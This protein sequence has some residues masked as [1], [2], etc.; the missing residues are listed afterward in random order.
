MGF[1]YLFCQ[2]T[3]TLLRGLFLPQ[4][5]LAAVEYDHGDCRPVFLVCGHLRDLADH[6]VEAPDDSA[7]DD[8][9]A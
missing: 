2:N 5:E 3:R 9:L 4:L 6:V 7:K 8:V 1:P